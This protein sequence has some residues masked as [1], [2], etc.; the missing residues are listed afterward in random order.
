MQSPA[1]QH[2]HQWLK[3]LEGSW[4]SEH[5]CVMGPD[6]P[7]IKTSGTAKGSTLGGLWLLFEMTGSMPGGAEHRSIIQ[8]GYDPKQQKFVGSFISSCMTRLW[9]YA[10]TLDESG[11]VLTL[12]SEGPTFTDENVMA[13]YQDIIEIVDDNRFLFRSRLQTPD[14]QWVQFMEGTYERVAASTPATAVSSASVTVTPHLVCAD[15]IAAIDFYKRAFNAN[16]VM[17]LLGPT[18]KLV[19]AALKIGSGAIMLAEENP[20]WGSLGPKTLKGTPVTLHLLVPDVDAAIAQAVEAG[21]IL[22]MPAADMF[23]GDRYGQVADPFGHRWSLATRK[24]ELTPAE[25]QAAMNR[26]FGSSPQ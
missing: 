5:D 8:L 16:E 26:A 6:Q 2:E 4:I 18:G 19:H 7:P 14:G 9:P 1:P 25:M 17:R 11:K 3:Q 13:A 22:T 15:A 24:Q 10:G 12:N 23:W 21:A 20:D